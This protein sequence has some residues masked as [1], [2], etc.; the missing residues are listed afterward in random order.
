MVKSNHLSNLPVQ[1]PVT[2]VVFKPH[3]HSQFAHV[4]EVHISVVALL[5]KNVALFC[6]LI[7]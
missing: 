2:V 1:F 3:E 4:N 7:L 5:L 6:L